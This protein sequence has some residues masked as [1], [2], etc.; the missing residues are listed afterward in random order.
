LYSDQDER[1]VNRAAIEQLWQGFADLGDLEP[2]VI[3]NKNQA[4]E[5]TADIVY[6][7]LSPRAV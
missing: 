5:T 4:A 1:G 2:F 7:R 3:D 6:G